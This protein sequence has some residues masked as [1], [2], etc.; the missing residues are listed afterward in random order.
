[1]AIT[2]A[3]ALSPLSEVFEP[4]SYDRFLQ[5]WEAKSLTQREIEA[6]SYSLYEYSYIFK[7]PRMVAMLERA[8][9]AYLA[10][11][12]AKNN[13]RTTRDATILQLLR[14]NTGGNPW[15]AAVKYAFGE[16]DS[17][18]NTRSESGKM[19][20]R[21]FMASLSVLRAEQES[22]STKKT[23]EHHEDFYPEIEDEEVAEV[24]RTP[25]PS[26]MTLEQQ[27]ETFNLNPDTYF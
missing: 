3:R 22:S 10:L 24:V 18:V 9:Y 17:Q 14:T 6:I 25:D 16:V 1:M 23:P 4:A 15:L 11:V 19:V 2:L 5:R 13:V 20:F 7:R 12:Q 27:I 26:V 8:Q 21:L